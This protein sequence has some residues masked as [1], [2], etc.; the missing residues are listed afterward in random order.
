MVESKV[1]VLMNWIHLCLSV[2]GFCHSIQV[3]F[4]SSVYR[5]FSPLNCS[6]KNEDIRPRINRIKRE[7]IGVEDAVLMAYLLHNVCVLMP[8]FSK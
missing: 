7:S 3:Y 1:E 2:Q 4:T 8:Q 6:F 5:V